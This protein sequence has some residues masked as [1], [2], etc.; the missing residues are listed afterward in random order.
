MPVNHLQQQ[1]APEG[2]FWITN[3]TYGEIPSEGCR[4]GEKVVEDYTAK[5]GEDNVI[6]SDVAHDMFGALRRDEGARAVYIKADV[7][8]GVIHV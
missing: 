4:T 7:W 6:V 8:D 3:V 2:F 1:W 5:Y